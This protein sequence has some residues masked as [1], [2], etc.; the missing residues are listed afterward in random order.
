[1]PKKTPPISMTPDGQTGPQNQLE[2]SSVAE[3]KQ[4]VEDTR[5]E[6]E[7]IAQRLGQQGEP[8]PRTV[9]DVLG[10]APSKQ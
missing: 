5:R 3:P 2:Y 7:K 6:A 10:D 9:S 1:M 8:K 4:T